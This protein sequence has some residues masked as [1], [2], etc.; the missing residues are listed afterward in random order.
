[1]NKKYTLIKSALLGALLLPLL[2]TPHA[3]AAGLDM[4]VKPDSD[5]NMVDL[6]KVQPYDYELRFSTMKKSPSGDSLL[7]TYQVSPRW[8]SIEIDPGGGKFW[9]LR[10]YDG[11][12]IELTNKSNETIKTFAYITNMG[13]SPQTPKNNGGKVVIGAGS[14]AVL[15]IPFDP[16]VYDL[17]LDKLAYMRI[18]VGTL[19]APAEF[20]IHSI[21][22]FKYEF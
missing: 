17:E 14:R 16:S 19:N 22:A 11:V 20:E 9:D 8:P 18:F 2:M 7:V 12:E 6:A 10:G 1:M 13:D 5:G 4:T 3:H 15:Q 21:K